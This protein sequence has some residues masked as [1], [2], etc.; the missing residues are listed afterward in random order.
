MGTDEITVMATYSIPIRTIEHYMEMFRCNKHYAILRILKES[1]IEPSTIREMT[2]DDDGID[3]TDNEC[4][5]E[6]CQDR[7]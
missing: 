7:E 1:R 5:C 3:Y 6:F 2:F 4:K